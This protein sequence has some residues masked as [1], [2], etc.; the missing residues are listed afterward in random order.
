MVHEER[1]F[2][3]GEVDPALGAADPGRVGR[4]VRRRDGAAD[5]HHQPERQP[6]A[7]G[8]GGVATRPHRHGDTD[9]REDGAEPTEPPKALG[10]LLRLLDLAQLLVDVREVE[11][12]EP[13]LV[14]V[15]QPRAAVRLRP[16]LERVEQDAVDAALVGG[17]PRERFG[18]WT[19]L[20]GRPARRL[21]RLD[22]AARW[23][24]ARP[25]RRRTRLAGGRRQRGV[26]LD[27][28]AGRAERLR[29]RPA[30]VEP[31]RGLGGALADLAVG[32]AGRAHGRRSAT[33]T[34]TSERVSGVITSPSS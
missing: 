1:Q 23:P 7:E 28:D 22:H 26:G 13:L 11:R 3:E 30:H 8:R 32:E 19:R 25:L 33:G 27:H 34:V 16:D 29:H 21:E 10:P 4:A 20:A 18:L 31:E 14:G 12:F 15:R 9:R 5:H 17:E 6:E 24:G 2:A